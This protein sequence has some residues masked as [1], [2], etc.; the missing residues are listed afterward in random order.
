M[1]DPLN[2][3]GSSGNSEGKA[4]AVKK[5]VY[6]SNLGASDLK[7]LTHNAYKHVASLSNSRNGSALV[8]HAAIFLLKVAALE[9]VRRVSKSKCP[10]LWRGIQAAQFLCYPPFKWIQKWAPLKGLINGVQM[11]SRPLLFLSMATAFSEQSEC[12]SETS[13]EV[14]GSQAHSDSETD[15]QSIATSSSPDARTNDGNPQGIISENWLMKLLKELEIQDITL[16]ERIN[17]DELDRFYA[18][19]NGDFSCLLSSIKKTIRWR[20]NYR[21]LSEEELETWSKMVFWHGY[22]VENRPCLIVRLGFACLNLPSDERPRFAQALVS[23]VEHGVLHLVDRDNPKIT[24]LV[25]CDGISPL[26]LPMQMVRSCSS[27]LQ[28][29]FP[30]RLGHL[31][32]IRL[33]PVVRVI[34]QT[35]IQV[36]KPGTRKK[37]R[38]EGSMYHRVICEYLQTIPSYLGGSCTCKMCS[39]IGI[40]TMQR[41]RVNEIRRVESL[42]CLTDGGDTPSSRMSFE[43]DVSANE[44]WDQLLRT[45]V[46]GMLM[47]WV[48]IALIAVMYDPETRPF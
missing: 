1:G 19:A 13:N 48:F 3:S 39:N 30:N 9:T 26:R 33:P 40:H 8:S 22:D 46:I 32:V 44:N 36:L 41:S 24:V 14:G 47:V 38:I 17:E 12:D 28:D 2:N 23:Q 20:D 10:P 43:D 5:K 7:P 15:S 45:A 4:L 25:D 29:N 27:L 34:A 21:I 42:E 35:F 31:L 11:F 18:A 6:K 16:P 37:L